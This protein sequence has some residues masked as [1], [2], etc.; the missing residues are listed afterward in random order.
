MAL[1][2]FIGAIHTR[3][4]TLASRVYYGDEIRDNEKIPYVTFNYAA[5]ID[6]ETLEDFII[7]VDI[8]GY[9]KKL[10]AL[11]TVVDT[12][13]GDGDISNPTGMNY[14]HYGTGASPTFSCY[15]LTRLT[16]PT[17]EEGIARRQLRYRVRTYL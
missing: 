8:Y 3:L 16:I 4:S 11:E 1:T 5:T 9:S 14:Y 15:R 7:E 17:G 6:V 10:T 2:T 13:D 12:I